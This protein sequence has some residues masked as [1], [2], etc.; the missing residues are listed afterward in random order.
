MR[1]TWIRP[2]H[3]APNKGK[4]VYEGNLHINGCVAGPKGY[5]PPVH[6]SHQWMYGP[7]SPVQMYR[8]MLTPHM[9]R[10]LF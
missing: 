4:A 8:V 7:L 1:H 10:L 5:S 6:Q 2:W 9:V 3:C